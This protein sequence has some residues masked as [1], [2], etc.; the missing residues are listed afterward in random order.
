MSTHEDQRKTLGQFSKKP[1]AKGLLVYK[2]LDLKPKGFS[3]RYFRTKT[4]AL[5]FHSWD[6]EARIMDDLLPQSQKE[7][8]QHREERGGVLGLPAV[9]GA[10]TDTIISPYS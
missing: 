8:L 4:E 5:E 10:E 9:H 6:R 2:Q 1:W 7:R 3:L